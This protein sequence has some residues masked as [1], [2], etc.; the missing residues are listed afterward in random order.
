M[1]PYCEAILHASAL[2]G[3][4]DLALY[5]ASNG[6]LGNGLGLSVFVAREKPTLS[7]QGRTLHDTIT[8]LLSE[9]AEPSVAL[10]PAA[11]AASG[12]V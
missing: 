3:G 6:A 11:M 2:R 7:A 9:A 12:D 5:V 8:H 1:R 10:A 4:F